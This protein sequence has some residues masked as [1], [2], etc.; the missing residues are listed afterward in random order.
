MCENGKWYIKDAS[1][2]KTTYVCAK[3]KIELAPGDIIILGNRRF[4][5]GIK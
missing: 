4:E 3:E 1:P 5:F 2:L